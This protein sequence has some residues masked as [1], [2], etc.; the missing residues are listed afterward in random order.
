LHTYLIDINDI[1]DVPLLFTCETLI[2]LFEEDGTILLASYDDATR[3][4]GLTF[5]TFPDTDHEYLIQQIEQA[6]NQPLKQMR[7]RIIRRA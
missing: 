3:E 4:V 7:L 5:D 1:V 6:F 2:E